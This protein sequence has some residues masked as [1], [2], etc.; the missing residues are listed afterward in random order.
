MSSSIADL[1]LLGRL[2]EEHRPR[3]LAMV[4]RRIDPALAARVDA[5]GIL[6]DAF[7]LARRRWGRGR[8]TLGGRFREGYR[9]RSPRYILLT[10]VGRAGGATFSRPASRSRTR[11][12]T[13]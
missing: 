2:F 3:L 12:R 4:Q 6:T 11:R 1:A 13:R 7:L 8:R 10:G 9:A 5:E